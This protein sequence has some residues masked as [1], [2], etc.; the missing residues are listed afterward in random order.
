MIRADNAK[1][2]Q[3]I[4]NLISNAIKFTGK[5]GK[6]QITTEIV[7]MNDDSNNIST[8]TADAEVGFGA[9]QLQLSKDPKR[10]TGRTNL[11][12]EMLVLKV[13]DSGAGIS[14]VSHSLFTST[15]SFICN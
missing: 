7:E 15:R 2:S 14:A 1:L 5:N 13:T 6:V 4:R 11:T 9:G 8:D 12:Q 3:V 10:P